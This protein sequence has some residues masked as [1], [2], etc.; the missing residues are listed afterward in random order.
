MNLM[1]AAMK[2]KSKM[3]LRLSGVFVQQQLAAVANVASE[4]DAEGGSVI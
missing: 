2:Q 1:L 3:F 4:V